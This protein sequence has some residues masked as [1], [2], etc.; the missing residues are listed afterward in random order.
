MKVFYPRNWSIKT[1]SYLLVAITICVVLHIWILQYLVH[2]NDDIT[3]VVALRNRNKLL[4][5][6]FK[7]ILAWDEYYLVVN[8][9]RSVFPDLNCSVRNCIFTGNEMYFG[10]DHSLFDA[11]IFGE[12]KLEL[13]RQPKKR[14]Q[15]QLYIFSTI[16]SSYNKPACEIFNDNFFNWTSTYRLDSTVVW[17]YF[18]VRNFS[19]AIVAPSVSPAWNVSSDPVRPEIRAILNRKRR[20]A[21]WLVSHC[22]ADSMR[23]DYLSRL[24]NYLFQFSL[25][26]DIYG[27][28]SKRKCDDGDCYGMIKENYYFYMAFENSLS[29]DYV[30]EKVLH[31]YLNHAVPVVYG[32]A[33]YSRS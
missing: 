32:G 23:D 26:I 15:T 16:E 33:N 28:C 17:N 7:Y 3:S 9:G 31:G 27:N 4:S 22:R 24:Q 25:K 14:S 21:A 12:D 1:L 30:T 6:D 29:E 11:I 8:D 19:G 10:G 2:L 13:K 5:K 18:L 20:G